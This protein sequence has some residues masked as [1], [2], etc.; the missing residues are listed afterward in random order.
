MFGIPLRNKRDKEDEP[1]CVVANYVK[2]DSTLDKKQS[3][4]AYYFTKCCVA[5][6]IIAFAWIDGKNNNADTL[7]KRLTESVRD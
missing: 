4:I 7:T 1:T 3:S 6:G 2:I 5:T